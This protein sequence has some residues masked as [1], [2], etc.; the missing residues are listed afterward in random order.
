MGL[1]LSLHFFSRTLL[2][3]LDLPFYLF[4]FLFQFFLV[5]LEH[6]QIFFSTGKGLESLEVETEGRKTKIESPGSSTPHFNSPP[7]LA[8]ALAL[9]DGG[10]IYSVSGIFYQ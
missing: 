10:D 9:Q 6:V 5:I 4:H 3:F 7:I 8:V 1:D 2:C